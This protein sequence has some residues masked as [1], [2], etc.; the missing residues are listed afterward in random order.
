MPT[1]RTSDFEKMLGGDNPFVWG[2]S[3]SK[4]SGGKPVFNRFGTLPSEKISTPQADEDRGFRE[5]MVDVLEEPTT[6][7]VIAELPGVDKDGIDL[8]ATETRMIL[9]AKGE[10]DRVYQKELQFPATIIPDSAKAKFK[11]GVLEIEF[12]RRASEPSS[13]KIPIQ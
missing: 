4:G 3:F 8:R 11:N 12:R 2:F 6:V 5:P 13:Q 9:K 10:K 1:N 7:R